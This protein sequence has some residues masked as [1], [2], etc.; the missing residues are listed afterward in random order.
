VDGQKVDGVTT[1]LGRGL[2]KTALYNWAGREAAREAVDHWE[3][4]TRLP[5][6]ER[7]ERIANAPNASRDAAGVRGTRVHKIAERL[8]AGER[9]DVPED[10]RGHVD[11]CVS[12]IDAW[13]VQPV[14]TE[15]PVFSRKHKFA[16]S[17]DLLAWV[18]GQD[19]P[20]LIDW[21]T[22]R[23][24]PYGDVA[25]QLAAYA[26]ADFY[27]VPDAAGGWAEKPVP[28]IGPHWAVW[29]RGDGYGVYPME[30]SERVFRQFLFIQQVATAAWESRD[31]KGDELSAPVRA[32]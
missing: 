3:E 13:G 32:R 25:F 12:F 11:A 15:F 30:S 17:P 9:V 29:L 23:K 31:Y 21:K 18:H 2:P 24:G 16:G 10:I 7:Y 5:V 19:L 8:V 14:L 6:M 28:E 22:N 20:V 27:L 4:L 1:I 26:G